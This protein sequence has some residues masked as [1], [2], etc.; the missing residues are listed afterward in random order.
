MTKED[1]KKLFDAYFDSIR[2][3][4]FYKGADTEEA[5]DLAQD[6]FMRVWEKQFDATN[7][8]IVPLLYKMANDMFISKYRRKQLEITYL[9]GLTNNEI[10]KNSP[11]DTFVQKELFLKYQR[12]LANLSEK[13]R[14]VFLM[15]RMDGLSYKEIAN[16]LNLSEKAIEKRMNLTISYLKKVLQY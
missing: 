16:R 1:F 3:Y 15:S 9:N 10:E 13:K 6:V 8:S 4:L 5:T 2:N 11:E 7:Q 14:S 12:A